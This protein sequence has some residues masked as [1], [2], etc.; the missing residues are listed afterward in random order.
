MRELVFFLEERSAEVLFSAILPHLLPGDVTYRCIVFE[1]KQDLDRSLVRRMRGYLNPDARFVIL[2]DQDLGDCKKIKQGL[3]AKC[4]EAGRPEAVVR[5]ICRE[6]ESWYLADLAAVEKG[7]GRKGLSDL[8]GKRKYRIPDEIPYPSKDLIRLV[9]SY[10][11]I[12][13]TRLIGPHL[14]L[15][16]TRSS[17]FACLMESLGKMIRE[18]HT[19]H[20]PVPVQ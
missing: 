12:S 13:G 14:D 6:L 11:K 7:L 10:Q 3:M 17:S 18:L 1:G 8:Q 16:N 20:P 4:V 5:I 2:R 19:D 15:E 9:P